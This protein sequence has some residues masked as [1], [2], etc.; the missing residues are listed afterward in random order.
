MK[1]DK[2]WKL[3]LLII[4][5]LFLVFAFAWIIFKTDLLE[6]IFN[7]FE[8]FIKNNLEYAYLIAFLVA[9]AEGTII[10]GLMPGTSYIVMM[11]ILWAKGIIDPLLLFPIIILGATMGDLLG[12]SIGS[13]ISGPLKKKFNDNLNYKI[14]KKFVEKHGPKSVFIARFVTGMKE[15]V[16]FVMG[17]LNMNL[18]KF[19]TFN[20]LGAIGWSILWVGIG[21]LAG[22]IVDKAE[23][24]VK[25]IGLMILSI[26]LFSIYIFYKKHKVKIKYGKN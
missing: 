15:I 12:Y 14:G 11:G 8:N 4:F 22:S 1:I 24:F 6:R 7:L 19:M 5:F 25:I 16:P 23:H 13:F 18:K 10:L 20:F 17:T 21:F 2:K 26:F 3:I 9:V